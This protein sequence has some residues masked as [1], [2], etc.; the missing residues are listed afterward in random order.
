MP[1]F[2][3]SRLEQ[4]GQVIDSNCTLE[5]LT[6]PFFYFFLV[7]LFLYLY[8][9]FYRIK[10][11]KDTNKLKTMTKVF[12]REKQLKYGKR[13]LYL[14]FYPPVVHPETL[15]QTQREHL[16]LYIFERPK[17]ET[18]K[19]QNKET[20]ML[21]DSIRSQ[22]QLELQAGAYGFVLTRNR[23]KDFIEYFQQLVESK[24]QG[25]RNTYYGWLSIFKHLKE[26]SGGTCRF[27]DVTEKFAKDFRHYLLSHKELS[28]NSTAIYF[29]KFKA[30]VRHAFEDRLLPT[31]PTKNIKSIKLGDTQREFLT[32]EEL[33]TLADTPFKFEDLRRATLFSTLTGLRYSD[34]EKLTWSEVQHS[35]SQGF[36]IRFTQQKTKGIETLPI[37]E[38]AFELLGKKGQ[39]GA[40]VFRDLE[41]A[42]CR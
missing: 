10:I 27:A 40:K 38:E 3:M 18:E 35:A 1:F 11:Q 21:A 30:G 34:I 20:R 22:R 39:P 28:N 19:D 17:S 6:C 36:Y 26:F 8:C 23:Q 41:Y 24:K 9:I 31:N 33:Q 2:L 7:C 32:L 12:L 37:G 29:E 15:Q 13:G 14:D 42:Q 16:R 4:A 5:I 25:S